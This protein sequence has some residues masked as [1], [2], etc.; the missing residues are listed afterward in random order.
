MTPSSLATGND[1]IEGGKGDRH[2]LRR[3]RRL[4]RSIIG[5]LFGDSGDDTIEGGDGN[6]D[7]YGGAGK[8]V[9]LGGPGEDQ[10]DG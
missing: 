2:D 7:V 4:T 3:R 9:L 6:D 5:G 8:D 1:Y 10:L